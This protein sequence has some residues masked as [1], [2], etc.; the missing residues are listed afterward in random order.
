MKVYLYNLCDPMPPY[1]DQSLMIRLCKNWEIVDDINDAKII[2]MG[3]HNLVVDWVKENL[4]SHQTLAILDMYHIQESDNPEY[5]IDILKDV[6]TNVIVIQQNYRFRTANPEN[7]DKIIWYDHMFDRQKVYCTDYKNEYSL[8]KCMWTI[9]CNQEM[10]KLHPI[11]KTKHSKILSLMRIYQHPNDTL[12]KSRMLYRKELRDL[13]SNFESVLMSKPDS[14]EVFL[15]KGFNSVDHAYFTDRGRGGTWLPASYEFY[16]NSYISVYVETL[17]TDD[18]TRMHNG[19]GYVTE[20]TFDPMIQ[21]NFVLPFA[22]PNFIKDCKTLYG[23]KFPEWI[24]YSYDAI[25]NDT[26]RFESFLSSVK[27]VNEYSIEDLHNFYIQDSDIIEHNRNVFFNK[28]YEY[29][30]LYNKI[31]ATV[32]TKN[33]HYAYA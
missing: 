2:M 16:N 8:H 21:G 27:K 28:P 7:K 11:C 6:T 26:D 22:Y 25:E 17:T 15:P 23:F 12:I 31:S 29:N 9:R 3:T 30:S 4:K 14:G 1:H 5:Y 13:L 19:N 33:P 32:N 20:K 10:F 18:S 24:D